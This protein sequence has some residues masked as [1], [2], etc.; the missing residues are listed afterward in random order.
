[1]YEQHFGFDKRPFSL[2]PDT[3]LFVNLTD[4]DQCFSLLVH[5]L[6]T[7]EGFLKVVGEVGTGKTILC[8]KLLRHLDTEKSDE[9]HSVYI[10]NPILSPIGLYRAVG[11]EL[12]LELDQQNDNDTLLHHITQKILSLAESD[13]GVV[14]VVDEAQSL[15][16]ETLEALRLITNLETEERKL[17]QVILFG[18]TELDALLNQDRFRQLR[19]RITFSHYLQSLSGNETQQYVDYRL[20]QSGYNGPPL[21]TK[22]AISFLHKASAGVPRMINVLAHKSMM[23]AYSDQSSTVEPTHVQ[24]ATRDSKE[25]V[26]PFNWGPWVVICAALALAAAILWRLR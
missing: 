25:T 2:S 16:A 6:E 17:V 13:K 7:G 4:H 14:I 10:P 9:F 5:V 11:Q 15:P 8:R 18:Q 19:Q 23:A 21:F 26:R 22:N 20:S 1:M 3:S 12:D 24:R